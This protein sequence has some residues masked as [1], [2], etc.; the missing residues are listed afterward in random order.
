MFK[1]HCL[2]QPLKNC[3]IGRTYAPEFYS[4][5]KDIDVRRRYEQIAYE[6][7]ED[8]QNLER[9]LQSFGVKTIRPNVNT[10]ADFKKRIQSR[11]WYDQFELPSQYT[12]YPTV[13]CIVP[14]PLQPRD[15]IMMMGDKFIHWFIEP[16]QYDQYRNIV[17]Y[18]QEQNN[19]VYHTDTQLNSEGWMTKIG[20][21]M[22]YGGG[23]PNFSKNDVHKEY[24][25]FISEFG[26]GYE[27][28]IYDEIGWRDSWYRPLKPN[29]II[30]V[31]GENRYA[32]DF[33]NW[34]VIT[35]DG[36]DNLNS[37]YKY[38]RFKQKHNHNLWNY[39]EAGDA[40]RAAVAYEW[41]DNGWREYC[42]EN[43]FDCNMLSVDENN[44]I[45]FN[46]NKRI[47]NE[48]E[49]HGINV[50]VSHYRHRYFWSGGIHCITCD[51]NRD[52]DLIDYFN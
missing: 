19:W 23:G 39:G 35:T 21:R 18:V 46:Y 31:T 40:A 47:C 4:F 42:S 28:I 43:V 2:F 10:V 12:E 13:E 14:P 30:S 48:L 25:Q 45:V 52:G 8:Y 5:I 38:L 49:K 7:E 9:L 51:L 34:K 11:A 15:W 50:H 3:V 41:L 33:P 20:K 37:M 29:L 26:E 16:E 1:K 44:V 24:E 6:T 22:T 36:D 27:N 17:N 32:K